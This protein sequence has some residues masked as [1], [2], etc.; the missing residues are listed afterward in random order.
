MI[1]NYLPQ[2]DKI[3]VGSKVESR[4][5][6]FCFGKHCG[7]TVEQVVEEDFGYLMW[8]VDEGIVEFSEGLLEGV[9]AQA[10]SERRDHY[11]EFFYD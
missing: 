11:L 10:D 1:T 4:Y 2:K 5:A 3:Y 9:E 6:I 7:K 8:L